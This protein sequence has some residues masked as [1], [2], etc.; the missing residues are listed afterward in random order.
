MRRRGT[1]QI[2]FGL[3]GGNIEWVSV[4]SN[5]TSFIQN[6]TLNTM[7][8][9][10]MKWCGPTLI[11]DNADIWVRSSFCSKRENLNH[12]NS[13]RINSGLKSRIQKTWV[14]IGI[15]CRSVPVCKESHSGRKRNE[16]N[17]PNCDI[18]IVE[19]ELP[20]R[21]YNISKENNCGSFCIR[22]TIFRYC[23]SNRERIQSRCARLGETS[24][25]NRIYLLRNKLSTFVWSDHL[26][27]G[28]YYRYTKYWYSVSR[29]RAFP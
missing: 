14:G 23:A 28:Q 11:F 9:S 29:T 15:I 18:C 4:N 2:I 19:T 6:F 27:Q 12:P 25:W 16:Y 8:L 10:P 20:Y 1:Q 24:Q 3:C 7:I 5:K 21:W 26:T 22:C 17:Y 13:P